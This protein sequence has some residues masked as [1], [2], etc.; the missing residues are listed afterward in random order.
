VLKLIRSWQE[1]ISSKI[2]EEYGAEIAPQSVP[3]TFPP[4]PELGDAATPVAF[5][6]AKLLRKPPPVIAQ[7]LAVTPME[8]VRETRVAGG[9]LNLYLDRAMVLGAL[10]AGRLIPQAT[11]GKVVVEHTNI[12]PNKAAHV[13]HLRNAV[14][15]DTLVRCLRYLGRNVEVQNYIDDTG[16]QVADVV[17]GFQRILGLNG[18]QLLALRDIYSRFDEREDRD[19]GFLNRIADWFCREGW[20][21]PGHFPELHAA[22]LPVLEDAA[23]SR[24]VLG[25]ILRSAGRFDA[26]C[27][28]LYAKVGPWY[29]AA[30]EHKKRR[31]ETLHLM[32]AGNSETAQMAA[33]IAVEMVRC[34]LRTMARLG[35][36]YEVLPHESDILKS[37]FWTACFDKLKASGAVHLV[38]DDSEDKNRG[39]WVMALQESEEF[40]GL[41]DADKVIVRS[42]GTVTYIGKDMAY[43]LWKFGLLGRGFHFRR[44]PTPL[45]EVWRSDAVESEPGAP[46]FGEGTDVINVI[47][48]R[49]SYL[50]KIVREGL[51]QMGHVE[52]AARSV[53]FA[54]E[55]VALSQ[56]TASQFEELGIITLSEEDRHRPFVEMSGRKGLGIQADVLLDKLEDKAEAEIQKRDPD[57]SLPDLKARARTLAVSA[58]R[59]YMVKF[60][61][62]Q[63]V[64]FDLDQA[65]AFEGETG[66][67]LLYACVRAQ[68]ILKKAAG[69]GIE[70][71]PATPIEFR[72]CEPHL[73]EEGWALLSQFLRVPVQVQS[74]VDGLDLNLVARH[75]FNVAQAFHTYYHNAPVLQEPD[76]E[77]RRARLLTVALFVHFL[78]EGLRDLLGIE[79]PEKM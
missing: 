73:D 49:Q 7:A 37:G 40:Q 19:A 51:R 68:N 2:H 74:A 48:V 4:K 43:Q 66:P 10:V 76:V 69:Q 11:S 64:A 42:N 31:L 79:V 45:Y 34:H 52:E 50:Q 78:K 75:F 30:E 67:Y 15:G 53:H 59:Y 57:L 28:E 17:V 33:H 3:F 77:K 38:S 18:A 32:E 72:R 26:F 41:S 22:L 12:N 16:V 27:W 58:L 9:Y 65:L 24:E 46:P 21:D 61:R 62:N 20:K 63:V 1:A 8:G 60:G 39:C 14:L 35:V 47:D 44:F 54:Y 29:E 55:M 23:L 13:G 70:V 25:W 6:L 36:R 56:K 71:P 5:S